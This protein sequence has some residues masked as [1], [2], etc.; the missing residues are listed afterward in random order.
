MEYDDKQLLNQDAFDELS[1]LSTVIQV[2]SGNDLTV[3]YND[4]QIPVSQFITHFQ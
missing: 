3:T 1:Q 4:N 2:I